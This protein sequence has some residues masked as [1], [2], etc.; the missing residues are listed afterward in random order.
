MKQILPLY[1]IMGS[2]DCKLD[3]AFTLTEAIKGGITCFQFREKGPGSLQGTEKVALGRK[4]Q[5]ICRESNIPF[6]VND[7]IELANT[8]QAD[9]IH[10]GQDD[11]PIEEVVHKFVGNI[12]GLSVHTVEEAKQAATHNIDYI[13]VG[14]IFPTGTKKDAKKPVGASHIH[15]IRDAGIST[16][17]VGIG[18][19]TKQNAHHVIQ[20]GAEGISLISAISMSDYPQLAAKQLKAILTLA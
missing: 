13:G 12:I 11:M 7:D 15:T 16:P 6:I 10:V 5:R 4:L 20:A 3:P 9:G 2:Q 17:I 19:I 14:P 8:L 18:G 1:F